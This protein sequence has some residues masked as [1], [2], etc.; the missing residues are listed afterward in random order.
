MFK[1]AHIS[2]IHLTP[3]PRPNLSELAGKRLTGYLNWLRH[4]KAVHQRA[5]LN[6]LIADM[7]AQ[8]PDHI[9]VVGDL[10]NLSLP[11]EFQA[12][13]N[14]LEALGDPEKISVVPGNHD[15]YVTSRSEPGIDRWR[16]YMNS[17]AEGARY[18]ATASDRFPYVRIFGPIALIGL[19]TAIPTPPFQAFGTL[20]GQQRRAL[21]STLAQLAEQNLFRIVLIHHAPLEGQVSRRRSL[22][23]SVELSEI[24]RKFGA[25]LVVHGHNHQSSLHHLET[26]NGL[27]P[28]CGVPSASSS[29]AHKHQ[30]AA[31]NLYQISKTGTGWR[32]EVESRGFHQP[33]STT[34][35]GEIGELARTILSASPDRDR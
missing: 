27:I 10:V 4:R 30:P 14:W 8:A 17:N 5:V 1:L 18:K 28:I 12:A 32:C 26:A 13:Q 16:A 31:Y 15:A 11:E 23:D 19:S 25:E 2:D 7:Q 21:A 9:A 20:G 34:P 22:R 33:T 3:L 29:G 6:D 35:N 24:L